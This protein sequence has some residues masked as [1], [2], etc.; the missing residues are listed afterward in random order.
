MLFEKLDV[1]RKA[2]DLSL[3]IHKRSLS[4]PRFEQTELASQLRRSSKSI[5]ANVGEGMGKQASAK[6]VIKYLRT[7]LGSC[8]ETR[9]WLKYAKDL[10]YLSVE[11]YESFHEG[12]CSV[13]KM[14]TGLI[15]RWS[16]DP[17]SF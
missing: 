3:A 9:I 4:F 7:A 17:P 11:E 10:E 2:Y 14:L 8:D 16:A 15:K 6:D 5:C 1:F 13:G 12:Y